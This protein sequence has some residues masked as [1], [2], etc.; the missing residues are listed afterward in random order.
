M[1]IYA[2]SFLESNSRVSVLYTFQH[3]HCFF[4]HGVA[5]ARGFTFSIVSLLVD[6]HFRLNHRSFVLRC[7]LHSYFFLVFFSSGPSVSL[8]SGTVHVL[9]HSAI[10]L[11][12]QL[13]ISNARLYSCS[14]CVFVHCTFHAS[15]IGLGVGSFIV[16]FPPLTC[17]LDFGPRDCPYSLPPVLACFIL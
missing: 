13:I 3:H 10:S 15:Q 2:F 17:A 1:A 4:I 11:K 16:V 14:Q 8:W 9:I 6:S 5:A 7:Q 12:S